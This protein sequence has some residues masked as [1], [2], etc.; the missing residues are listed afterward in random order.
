MKKIITCVCALATFFICS[1]SK[2]QTNTFPASGS[3]GI[4]TTT[5]NASALLEIKSTNKGLLIPRMSKAKRDAIAS[6]AKG[7]LIYQNDNTPGFYYYNGTK[8]KQMG[9]GIGAN[10]TLSNLTHPTSVNQSLIPNNDNTKILGNSTKQWK[11][12]YLSDGIYKGKMRVFY[13]DDIN[14]NFAIGDSALINNVSGTGAYNTSL[15]S[16]TLVSN[17]TGYYNTAVGSYALNSNATGGFN[18]ASGASA[19]RFNTDGIYNTAS[20]Y[21]ALTSNTIGFQNSAN[22]AMA[23]RNNTEG[24]NNTANGYQALYFNT[25]GG[26]NVATGSYSLY[27]NTTGSD[28]VAN[29]K[30]SLYSETIGINNTANG[31]YSLY[32]NTTG[33]YNTSFGTMSLYSYN[34][35]NNTALGYNANINADG[36]TNSTMLG[37]NALATASNQVRIGSSDVTSIGGYVN[38]TNISDGRVKKNIKQNVPGL[39]FINKLKPVTYNLNLEAA[40]Q[41]IQRPAIK[42]KSGKTI[43]PSAEEMQARKD[44]ENKLYT[45]FVAQD[46]EKAAKSI[47]YDFSGVDAAKNSK[48][49][50]GLRY[51]EF[52]VPLVK[53]VQELSAANDAKDAKIDNLQ[54]QIDELKQMING[55]NISASNQ[56]S[57]TSQQNVSLGSMPSLEQNVPNPFQGTTTISCYLPVNNGNAYINFYSQSGALLKSIKITGKEKTTVTLHANELAA[58]AYKYALIVD[59]KV[60]ASRN[61]VKQ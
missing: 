49:L 45:G 33:S 47:G 39:A 58:G 34:G 40:D 30:Y 44:K 57:A 4:G 61:M 31:N 10:Q 54:K 32:S 48:D 1:N 59:G 24:Y 15:G 19:L 11:A 29:G 43:Q 9:E 41:I 55:K 13:Y 60:I 23:L 56:L 2:A 42:D 12:L 3:V 38:W 18:T 28:N 46:V 21:R 36:I 25:T 50:Y 5:P 35:S 17:T 27:S 37:Q 16:K 26:G 51:A 14:E 20:G 7:L 22:G 8:W 53:A 6:P 52:V